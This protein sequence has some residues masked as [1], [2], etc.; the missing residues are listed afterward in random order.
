MIKKLLSFLAVLLFIAS[1]LGA[2]GQ[3]ESA[4]GGEGEVV[5]E[6]WEIPFLNSLTG[7]IASIGEY[8]QWGAERAAEEI[9]EAGGIAG[10]P[11]KVVGV[12]TA[13]EPQKGVV[14]MGKIVE[15]ALVAL[16]P[17]PEP[18]IM[19]AAPI[20]VE[21]EMMT[22]TATT[23]LEYA[24]QF[25][26]W[27][28]SWF[29]KT[30]DRLPPL[31]TEWADMEGVKNVVQFVG[32]YG[33]WPGMA[34]AHV[35]G[36]KAAGATHVGDVEVPQDAVTFGPLVVKALDMDPDGIIIACWPDK[37]AKIVQ[38]LK[39]RGWTDM[40]KILLFSSAD[41]AALYTTGGSDLDGTIIYNYINVDQTN[42]RWTAFKDAYAADHNGLQPPS[43]STNYYDAVY[44]I[45][46][47]IEETG[48]T[49]D[50]KKLKEE[51]KLIAEAMLDMKSFEG[52]LFNWDMSGGVPTNK[53]TYLFEIQD[54][55]K[56]LVKEIRP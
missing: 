17:V 22:M 2:G 50:P 16:G 4:A 19:A 37:A 7:A 18:V 36:L 14:E 40:N 35:D 27:S 53:P 1:I 48:V 51:R 38:E 10:V 54:G 5:I 28:I 25:F 9:N 29:P 49:G 8:L 39:N 32:I 31:A 41:D 43:L 6:E 20:A 23:S 56:K 34:A 26:P 11:V 15:Y 21:N 3:Q 44:M 42:P 52:L 46:R 55:K 24:E 33:P 47:A 12:D 30:A 13:L 45:K